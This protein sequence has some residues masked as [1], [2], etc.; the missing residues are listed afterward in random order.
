MKISMSRLRRMVKEELSRLNESSAED[1]IDD[2]DAVG[3]AMD[4]AVRAA[5]NILARAKKSPDA[6]WANSVKADLK[7]ALARHVQGALG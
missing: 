5:M 4:D 6:S 1:L 3:E 2:S 7:K